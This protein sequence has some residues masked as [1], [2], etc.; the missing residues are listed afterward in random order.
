L[1]GFTLIEV[2]VSVI[3]VSLAAAVFFQLSSNAYRLYNLFEKQ[4][5]FTLASSLVFVENRGGVL[6]EVMRNWHIKNDN[7]LDVLKNKKINL[8]K[9]VDYKTEFNG[10]NFM[11]LKLKAYNKNN[12]CYVYSAKIGK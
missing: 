11:I 1:K 10:I 5:N 7:I 4:K 12:G 9:T 2:L 8:Q 6:D 3:I